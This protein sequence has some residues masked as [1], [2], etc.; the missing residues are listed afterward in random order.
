MPI[1]EY[2]TA[3]PTRACA[4]CAAPFEVI[5]PSGA[6]PVTACPRCGASVQKM[7]SRCLAVFAVTDAGAAVGRRVTEHERQGQWSHAAELAEKQSEKSGD[8]ALR[9]RALDN[10]KKAGYSSATLERHAQESRNA[11]NI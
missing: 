4:G 1:Y 8:R 6:A 11:D 7:V 5:R 9:E 10:Y 3:D 2:V